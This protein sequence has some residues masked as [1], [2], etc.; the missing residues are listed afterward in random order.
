MQGLKVT[1]GLLCLAL[2]LMTFAG[3]DPSIKGN[4]R[5]TIQG[6]MHQFI[7]T[8]SINNELM[9]FDEKEGKVLRLSLDKLHDGIVKKSSFYVSCADFKDQ[10]GRKIDIDFLVRAKG[11]DMIAT[12]A[13]VHSVDGKKRKYHLESM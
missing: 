1:L 2:P 11:D 4:L 12:Q 7:K 10:A 3:D 13:I 5:S 9:L 6:A 8:Q